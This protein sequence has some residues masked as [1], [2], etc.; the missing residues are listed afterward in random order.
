MAL[1]V[2]WL[3][4]SF[5]ASDDVRWFTAALLGWS[6]HTGSHQRS[7]KLST[8]D[9]LTRPGTI[10]VCTQNTLSRGFDASSRRDVDDPCRVPVVRIFGQQVRKTS[11]HIEDALDVDSKDV[12][13]SFFLVE[14][15]VG[16]APGDSRVVDED[17][18][19]GFVLS[20]FGYE[21]VAAC[22]RA[23]VGYDIGCFGTSSD[24]IDF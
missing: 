17:V 16:P 12:V 11:S 15:V 4:M 23:N 22:F 20:E 10:P 3:S 9:T 2:I 21:G 13:P 8:R 19:L 7:K 24:S 14:V 6:T 5:T 1:T 18:Q